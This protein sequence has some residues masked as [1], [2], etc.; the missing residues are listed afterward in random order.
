MSNQATLASVADKLRAASGFSQI[1]A[2]HDELDGIEDAYEVQ[3][4]NR[5]AWISQGRLVTGYKVAFTTVESQQ[6][7][8]ATEPV[9]GTLFEDMRFRSGRTIPSGRLANP[10][11]EGEIVLELAEDLPAEPLAPEQVIAVVGAFYVALEI[12]EAISKIIK[13]P[14]NNRLRSRGMAVFRTNRRKK[15]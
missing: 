10:K 3:A 14:A 7:F 8:G 11:L 15:T 9:Y 1:E 13:R 4:I 2:V 12:P 6:I 5:D